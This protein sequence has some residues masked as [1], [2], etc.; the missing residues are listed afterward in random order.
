MVHSVT[1]WAAA[2][3][4][5]QIAAV[6]TSLHDV[7]T[8]ATATADFV[9]S[10]ANAIEVAIASAAVFL[11]CEAVLGVA[12]GG[13]GAAA[14]AVGCGMLA[15][16]VSG[17]LSYGVQAAQTHTFSLQGLA[18]SVAAGGV[19]G[20]IGGLAGSGLRIVGGALS[21]LLT[22]GAASDA[23]SAADGLTADG[24]ASTRAAASTDPADTVTT[25][26]AS[27]APAASSAYTGAAQGGGDT[28]QADATEPAGS[29][30]QASP[31]T[32]SKAQAFAQTSVPAAEDGGR[33]ATLREA[34]EWRYQE[35]GG[36][37]VNPGTWAGTVGGDEHR[38]W[39]DLLRAEHGC[40][41]TTRSGT[42]I[43]AR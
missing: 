32:P 14:G 22:D 9:K 31:D 23:V 13:V 19:L 40:P 11:G 27:D 25:P 1:R 37:P 7:A 4:R 38:D 24:A 6:R 15:G 8:A 5:D 29:D 28:G 16:A 30:G 33:A 34:V 18:Q 17:A 20:E 42:S 43:C 2:G 3:V 26:A 41:E 39:P 10:H 36:E 35:S 12:T 21:R